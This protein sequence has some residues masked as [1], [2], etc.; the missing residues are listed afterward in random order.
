MHHQD[1]L[2][3]S[4]LLRQLIDSSVEFIA[5]VDRNLDIVLINKRYEDAMG[6]KSDQVQGQHLLDAVPQIRDSIQ[7]KSILRALEGETVYLDKRPGINLSS[8]Y[9]DTYYIPLILQEKIEG[10]II[11][12]RDITEM[13]KTEIL[14]AEKNAELELTIERIRNHEL[15]DK[16]KDNFIQMAS[17]ELKTPVTSIKGYI[18]YLLGLLSEKHDNAVSL[19]LIESTLSSV[20]KQLSRL[21][22]LITDLLDLTRIDRGRMDLEKEEFDLNELVE[23]IISDF[24]FNSTGHQFHII[25]RTEA[26]VFADK[27]R[28]RQVIENLLSNAVKYSPRNSNIDISIERT[29]QGVEVKVKDDGIGINK[30]DQD[31]V[32]ERFYR[33]AGKDVHTFPG[34]GI[35]LF[36]ASEI[37]SLHGGKIEVDSDEGKGATFMFSLP[38]DK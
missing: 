10:V 37:V 20:D 8:A 9:V 24:K 17:H 14:L 18:Q 31:R 34:F 38:A 11:M 28:I 2:G 25:K 13:V 3:G 5:V 33:V 16:Q 12:S 36:I 15:K 23:D 35:G 6:I 1:I 29:A 27:D 30:V 4:N 26:T 32:F 7:H 21:T 22:K 19:E